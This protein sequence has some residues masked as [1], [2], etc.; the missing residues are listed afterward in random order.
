MM[1]CCWHILMPPMIDVLVSWSSNYWGMACCIVFSVLANDITEPM[2]SLLRSI[3]N[4][5]V[6]TCRFVALF[7][8]MTGT[9]GRVT[10]SR[11]AL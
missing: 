6:S 11:Y 1:I 5:V 8:R 3:H 10:A 4:G 9:S 2:Q 7:C